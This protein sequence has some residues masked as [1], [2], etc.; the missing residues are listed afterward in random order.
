MAMQGQ[1][2]VLDANWE[3][4]RERVTQHVA[5]SQDVLHAPG[6][7]CPLQEAVRE[8]CGHGRYG[9]QVGHAL[10]VVHPKGI[11]EERAEV[12][13]RPVQES[14]GHAHHVVQQALGQLHRPLSCSD[15]PPGLREPVC[16]EAVSSRLWCRRRLEGHPGCARVCNPYGRAVTGLGEVE[17]ELEKGRAVPGDVVGLGLEKDSLPLESKE[18]L[19]Q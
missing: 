14:G 4:V 9:V 11:G 3:F 6:V 13:D 16:A 10:G 7:P 5:V 18:M 12:C 8:G 17:F 1:I 15:Y 19:G 2:A